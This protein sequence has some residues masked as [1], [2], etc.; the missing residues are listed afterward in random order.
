MAKRLFVRESTTDLVN[1]QQA[2]LRRVAAL[3][4]GAAEAS[5]VFAAVAREVA[6]VTGSA[7]VQI[8]RFEPDDSVIVAGAWGDRPHPFQPGTKWSLDGSQIAAAIKRTGEVVRIDDFGAGAGQI[9]AGVR[10]TGIRGGAGAPIVVAGEL[11][12]V[13]A[14]GPAPGDPVPAGLEDALAEFTELVATAIANTESRAALARMAEEQAALRRVATLVARGDPPDEV[15]GAVADELATLVGTEMLMMVRFDEDEAYTVLAGGGSAVDGATPGTRLQLGGRNVTTMV[16]DTGRPARIDDYSTTS[17]E[18]AAYAGQFETGSAVGCPVIVGGRVWGAVIA[19]TRGAEPMPPQTEAR[20]VEFTEL[21]ATAFANTE[22]RTEV[23][24]LVDEQAALRRVATMV[25][26]NVSPD[27]LFATTAEEIGALLGVDAV[28]MG[29]F[30]PGGKLAALAMWSATGDHPPVPGVSS[31]PGTLAETIARTG[32]AARIDDWRAVEGTVAAFVRDELGVRSSVGVP[33]KVGDGVWGAVVVH[34]K[35]PVLPPDAESRLERFAALIVTALTNADARREIRRLADEQA[36]LRRVATLVA[37]GATPEEVFSAVAE[38]I[39]RLLGIEDT[40]MARYEADETLTIVARAGDVIGPETIGLRLPLG[41]TNVVTK[42]WRT[43]R[44]AR[45]DDHAT[46]TGEVGEY[47]RSVGARATVGTPIVVDGRVWGTMV[48]TSTAGALPAGTEQ[49]LAEFTELVATAVSN[50]EA[51][52]QVQRLVD[53]QAAL[54]RIAMMIAQNAPADELFANVVEEAGGLLGADAAGVG[55]NL[56]DK[57]MVP[58]AMWAADGS[59]PPVPPSS[60]LERDSLAGIIAR[61]RAP[62]R[63]DDWSGRRSENAALIREKL[64]VRSSVGVPVMIDDELWGEIVVHSKTLLLPDTESRLQRF[65]DLVGTGLSNAQARG[66]VR[67]LADEQ[68]ALRRVATLVAH[69]ATPDAVFGAVAE[70]IARLLVVDD[71]GMVRYEHDETATVVGSAS[72]LN[73]AELLGRRLPL[74]GDNV[75]TRV[76]RTGRAARIDDHSEASGEIGEYARAVGS[77][78]TVGTPIVVDGR[79]WGAMLVT[80]GT[81]VLPPETAERVA[82]FTELVAT[83]IA[84]VEARE[85]LAASRARLVAAA[86]EERRRVVRDLHDGAQQRQVHTIVTLKLADRALADS[87]E[88][89][90]TLVTDALDNAESANAELREL[91]QGI[92]PGVLTRGGL[93]AGVESLVSRM[94]IPVEVEVPDSRLPAAVEATA[95]FVVAEALT[96]VVK[97]AHA[98]TAAVAARVEDGRLQVEVRDDGEGG[99]NPDG[100]GLIGLRDR[101]AALDGDLSV[102]SPAG[103][104]TLVA[105]TIPLVDGPAESP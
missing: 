26:R 3:I 41:G 88:E 15:F 104:G 93:R 68:A 35:T 12:G 101:V 30:A 81:G 84:N 17:G 4:A 98:R 52:A 78:S 76:H 55:R 56:D 11:W 22:A 21:V 49:R 33:I 61:T 6:Q 80:S 48:V 69:E 51:R 73:G 67:R 46:S 54:R 57:T 75:L 74:G 16:H 43:G 91:A 65:A 103:A 100:S 53:E 77:R 89:A 94:S 37:Q 50:T 38:E 40:G 47:V 25:A 45:V 18:P 32:R 5:E 64:G 63:I 90:R 62:A 10:K 23:Q 102:D 2:A 86:D 99:A 66:E 92:M 7:L 42:V 36:A 79:L 72:R 82:E 59:H 95:Y 20:M 39:G 60:P 34:M 70:E 97:H 19:A 71:T 28:G 14:A 83:A 1:R 24:R 58:L 9:Q 8:Q 105:A 44:A 87:P 31:E 13:M 96:N 85:D 29:R 27:E